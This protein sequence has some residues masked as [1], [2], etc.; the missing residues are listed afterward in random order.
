VLERDSLGEVVDEAPVDDDAIDDDD[1]TDD[2]DSAE[3]TPRPPDE[4]ADCS[5]CG[6]SFVPAAAAPILSLLPLVLRR[7]RRSC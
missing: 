2:D 5:S 1:A 6:A 7:R 4:E 3:P